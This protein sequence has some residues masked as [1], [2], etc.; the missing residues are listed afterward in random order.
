M[1]IFYSWVGS[2]EFWPEV[3]LLGLV[4]L[5]PEV[6][7]L[8]IEI[9]RGYGKSMTRTMEVT[10]SNSYKLFVSSN[11]CNLKSAETIDSPAPNQYPHQPAVKSMIAPLQ[12]MHIITDF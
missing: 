11:R 7:L 3:R 9:P 6:G 5:N 1:R 4:A 8:L 10:K 12:A 2:I